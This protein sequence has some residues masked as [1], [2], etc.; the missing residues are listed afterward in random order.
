MANTDPTTLLIDASGDDPVAASALVPV[1]YDE[2]RRLA[3]GIL[4]SERVGI[5]LHATDLVHEAYLRLIDQTRASM[6]NRRHFLAIAAQQM[7]RILVDAARR[8]SAAKR[9][10]DWE[11]ITL[12]GIE[13]GS[14]DGEIDIE[15]LEQ[16]LQSLTELHPR[17]ANIV[18]L[19][20]FGGLTVA[21]VADVLSVS[22]R[23]VADDWRMA[24]AWLFHALSE[25]DDA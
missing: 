3:G 10:G 7:R 6:K 22:E 9:G 18:E 17:Q 14:T 1:V 24:K 8:R 13:D 11:R 4:R 2:L 25:G 23:T 15:K 21:E 19:R 5:T 20:Y 16:A 12:G